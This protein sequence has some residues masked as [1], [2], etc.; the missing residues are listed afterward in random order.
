MKKTKTHKGATKRFNITG[1]GKLEKRKAKRKQRFSRGTD[2]KAS[3][4]DDKSKFI[5][6]PDVRKVLNLLRK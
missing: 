6:K 4:T 1:S 2:S 3:N 5:K